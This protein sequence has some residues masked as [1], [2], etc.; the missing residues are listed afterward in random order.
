MLLVLAAFS[1]ILDHTKT[2][3]RAYPAVKG[4]SQKQ[5]MLPHV[6]HALP[7]H[8]LKTL[9]LLPAWTV[10]HALPLDTS[11]PDATQHQVGHVFSARAPRDALRII[12]ILTTISVNS[13]LINS[14]HSKIGIKE[15]FNDDAMHQHCRIGREAQAL[16][17]EHMTHTHEILV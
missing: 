14:T 5:K 10:R 11:S 15:A 4:L 3:P 6:R 1:A 17:A 2:R 12:A 13:T 8:T 9:H 16:K 7:P